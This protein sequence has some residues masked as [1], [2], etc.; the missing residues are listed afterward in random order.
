[1]TGELI[2]SP[3]LPS[4]PGTFP[5]PALI[6]RAGEKTTEQFLEFF[7]ATIRNKNTRAT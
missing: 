6:A 1:M 7:A 2:P 4:T 3:F 5:V